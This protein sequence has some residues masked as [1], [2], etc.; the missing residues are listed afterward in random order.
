ML[1]AAMSDD[2]T[3][4]SNLFLASW[5]IGRGGG[6]GD[7]DT[8]REIPPLLYDATRRSYRLTNDG[9]ASDLGSCLMARLTVAEPR[10]MYHSPEN[11]CVLLVLCAYN[12]EYY[13]LV[14]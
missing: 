9:W 7:L 6:G 11:F 14:H 1:L 8:H 10:I 2:C 13:Y 4:R 5:P 12:T 3:A